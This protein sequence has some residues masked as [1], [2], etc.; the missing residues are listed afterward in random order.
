MTPI[1]NKDAHW[2]LGYRYSEH[3]VLHLRHRGQLD[4]T[5]RNK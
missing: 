3:R 1:A 4:H 5:L 2:L